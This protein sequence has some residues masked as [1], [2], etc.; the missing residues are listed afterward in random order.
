MS[1]RTL[2]EK[3]ASDKRTAI[4]QATLNLISE[5]GFHDTPMSLIAKTSGV[6]TGIIYH[7]FA[8]KEE[9]IHEL[10][11]KIKI[12]ASRAMLA[13]YSEEMSFRERFDKIWFNVLRHSMHHPKETAFL[14]QFE[15][16]PYSTPSLQPEFLDNVACVHNFIV[17]GIQEGVFKDLP[18]E[19]LTDLT[20]GVAVAL[21]KRHIA[22]TIVLDD[23][24]LQAVANACWDAVKR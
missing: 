17:Q 10:Y 14:E 11:T 3:S 21:A 16:S 22:G 2:V 13:D 4:L 19:V 8:S 5:R 12:E 1:D 7:Y 20:I 6:S 15:N 9:L 18:F 24:L 23:E